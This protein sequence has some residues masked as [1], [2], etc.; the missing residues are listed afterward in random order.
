M[1]VKCTSEPILLI[2]VLLLEAGSIFDSPS[3]ILLFSLCSHTIA[4]PRHFHSPVIKTGTTIR[5]SPSTRAG[6]A[7]YTDIFHTVYPSQTALCLSPDH[8]FVFSRTICSLQSSSH[9]FTHIF[10]FSLMF[11]VLISS[12]GTECMHL[13]SFPC[14]AFALAVG[15]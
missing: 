3:T 15:S 1:W 12:G 10:S 5:N 14:A 4:Q 9:S 7:R 2:S 13:R 6:P 8:H 11:F